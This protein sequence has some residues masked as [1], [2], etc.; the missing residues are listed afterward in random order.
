M[1]GILS[2]TDMSVAKIS[3]NNDMI[4]FQSL[5]ISDIFEDYMSI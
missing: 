5:C 4:T 3:D 1:K 2:G